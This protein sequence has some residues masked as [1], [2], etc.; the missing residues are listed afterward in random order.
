MMVTDL[1]RVVVALG[2]PWLAGAIFVQFFWRNR[3]VG[4]WPLVIG[5]GFPLGFAGVSGGS[6]LLGNWGPGLSFEWL[7]GLLLLLG[8]FMAIGLFARR[9]SCLPIHSV[10]VGDSSWRELSGSLK[11]LVFALAALMIVRWLGMLVEV[12]LRPLFPWDAW[13]AYGLAAKAWFYHGQLDILANGREWYEADGP[14]YASNAIRH[15]PGVGLIQLWMAQA[16]GRW[17]DALVNLPWA[18]LPGAMAFAMYGM[19]RQARL[20]V[21]PAMIVVWIGLTIPFYNVHTVLA[22][23]GDIWVGVFLCVAVGTLHFLVRD[24]DMMLMVPLLAAVAGLLMMKES[25]LFWLPPLIAG[26]LASVLAWR[27]V[28][29]AVLGSVMLVLS[30][31]LLREGGMI[32]AVLDPLVSGSGRAIHPLD[33]HVWKELWKHLFLQGNWNLLWSLILLPALL[34]PGKGVLADRA[35]RALTI[36]M[37]IAFL[38][39]AVT[40]GF[41]DISRNVLDGTRVNRLLLHIVPSLILFGGFLMSKVIE[42]KFSTCEVQ[43]R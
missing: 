20:G 19:F 32:N 33:V 2:I 15:P 21:V 14:V 8:S 24:R 5:M 3:S 12:S 42:R 40:F 26:S 17:D 34:A 28:L 41:T 4:Y 23:Y 29:A 39:L 30:L 10:S 35:L 37:I 25:G 7:V 6:V 9:R 1:F 11:A 13:Q 43:S 16:L 18:V 36:I 38:M 27:W 22:G 31:S